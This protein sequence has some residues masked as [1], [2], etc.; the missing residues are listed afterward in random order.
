[1]NIVLDQNQLNYR[2]I[3]LQDAIKN[4]VMDNSNFIR[5]IYSTEDFVINGIYIKI[6]L[7]TNSIEKYFNKYKCTFYLDNN[8]EVINKL[9]EIEKNILE[10]I[11]YKNKT[12]CYRIK[13]QLLAGFIKMFI[14]KDHD[15]NNT[16]FIV[17]ISGIWETN[18]E[19]GLTFK[20]FE[21]NHP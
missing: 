20:F 5:I 1:M 14:S 4:T 18:S 7:N 19:Y 17:K 13:D 2:C 9:I 8:T 3:F 6:K 21:I 16:N 11:S 10:I 12:P 15:P